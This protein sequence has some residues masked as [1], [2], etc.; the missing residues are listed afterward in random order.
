MSLNPNGNN[1]SAGIAED[2][3]L[4]PNDPGRLPAGESSNIKIEFVAPDEEV[5]ARKMYVRF[6]V[7]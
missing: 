4:I 3:S 7:G 2:G 1:P 5:D 6:M